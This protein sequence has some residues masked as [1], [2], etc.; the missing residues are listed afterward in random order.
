MKT[1][2]NYTLIAYS[3][4]MQRGLIGLY[5]NILCS[6]ITIFSKAINI[7]TA[8]KLIWFQKIKKKE[9]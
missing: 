9:D 8:E 6:R 7:Y 2:L 4:A 5:Q 3:F 1:I